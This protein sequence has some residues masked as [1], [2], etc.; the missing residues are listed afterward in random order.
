MKTFEKHTMRKVTTTQ[1]L[2]NNN[3]LS[4]TFCRFRTAQIARKER[5]IVAN[6]NF[7]WNLS[8]LRAIVRSDRAFVIFQLV[9]SPEERM[10]TLRWELHHVMLFRSAI[11]RYFSINNTFNLRNLMSFSWPWVLQAG[12][13]KRW[14]VKHKIPVFLNTKDRVESPLRFFSCCTPSFSS[15]FHFRSC[16]LITVYLIRQLSRNETPLLQIFCYA[17]EKFFQQ[18]FFATT[19]W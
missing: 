7:R 14:T 12:L 8:S 6:L 17:I 16:L 5:C 4:M 9:L 2:K 13:D 3:S 10:S 19:S 18:F 1:S 15:W 11:Q